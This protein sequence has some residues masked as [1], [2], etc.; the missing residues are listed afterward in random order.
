MFS[1]T[2]YKL[3]FFA[4]ALSMPMQAFGH[5]LI[6]PALGVQGQGVRSD[7][8]RPSRRTPC[9]SVNIANAL[10]DTTPV[11]ANG[12]AFTVSVQNFNG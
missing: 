9:G 4:L 5:A 3:S 11:Q 1:S 2:F 7:V 12:N 6:E 10:A 8:Q